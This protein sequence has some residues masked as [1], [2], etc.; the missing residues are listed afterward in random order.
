[1]VYDPDYAAE[2]LRRKRFF[3]L[4]Q[5]FVVWKDLLNLSPCFLELIIE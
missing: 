1:V 2:S 5:G 3:A 4:R